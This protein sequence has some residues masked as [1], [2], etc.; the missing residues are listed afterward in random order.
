[1]NTGLALP[2]PD[3]FHA[4][5]AVG[6]LELGSTREA[7]VELELLD[8]PNREHPDALEVW[9]KILAAEHDWKAALECAE[10]LVNTAPDRASTWV[11]LAFALH[12]LKQTQEAFDRLHAVAHRFQDNFIIPYNLACYQCRMGHTADAWQWLKKAVKAADPR[13]IRAMALE[14]PDLAPLR[15]EVLRLA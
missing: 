9:W 8:A 4:S 5:A 3:C 10:K 2:P 1:M 14:D 13:M 7:R 12:E 11:S 15:S 6:W